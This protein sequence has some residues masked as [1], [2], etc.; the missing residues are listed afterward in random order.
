MKTLF[1]SALA[2]FCLLAVTFAQ[3]QAR[4]IQVDDLTK[5]ITVSDPQISP[6]G[7]FVVCVVS[8]QNLDQ[9]RA[10]HELV[11]VDVDTGSQRVL[12]YDRKDAGS[13]HWSPSG[14]R[15]AFTA[16]VAGGKDN[17][18]E[19]P[20]IF[21]LPM[22]G[23][24]AKKIT[25]AATGIEQFAWRPNGNDIAYVTSDEP[26]SKKQIEKYSDAFE[27]G[28]SDYLSK[29]A[30]KSSHIWLV[31][32]AGGDPKR[33]TSGSWSL[34]KNAP[35]SSPASPISW[36]PDGKFLTFV[37]Q[38]HPH[39]GDSDLATVQILTVDSG[40]IRKLTKHEKLEGF[41]L[42]SPDGSQ[43]TYWYPRDGDPNNE[44][45]I[46]VTAFAGGDGVDLTR[47]V[48][49]NLQRA[50]WMPDGKSLLVGGDDGTQVA[51]WLQPLQGSARK[52][53]LG[54]I[55]PTWFFWIDADVG[56]TGAIAFTGNSPAQ[57]S[58]L[59]YMASPDDPPKRL[60]DFNAPI[61]GLALGKAEKFE[62]KGPDGFHEDGVLVYPPEFKKDTK[63][64]LVLVIHGGPTAA[65]MVGFDSVAAI[66]QLLAAHDYVVF[67]PNYRGSDNLGNAY[68]RAIYNDAGGGPGRDVM[69]GIEA[70]KKLG[71]VDESKIAVSG[72]SYGGFMTS[73]L[74]GHYH[75]WKTAV[76]GASVTDLNEAYNLSDF[77]VGYRY[78]F[79]GSPWV[80]G[81]MKDYVAQSPIAYAAQIKTP[82]LIMSD[83]GDA[84]VPITQSY[85][86][87]H[88]L[89]DNGVVVKFIAYPIPG[90]F[91]EDPV[92]SKDVY[93]RWVAWID[94]YLK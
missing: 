54:D 80:G 83:T 4:R 38:E 77:N 3:A 86:L 31:P 81:N 1:L 37:K 47:T 66:S 46:F 14:D 24:D 69:A 63:Y 94:Q 28:D 22:N 76:A 33:L 10:D 89:K 18:E 70:V 30:L 51:M 9:D 20:Q 8:R 60:T 7:K 34:P 74:I 5:I 49:H 11:L 92:R 75:I 32:A 43:L 88:A 12:T 62:W 87:F 19:L 39:F 57:P 13:P 21:V 67:R 84:R 68:Q 26:E 48:D 53:R 40:E 25:N 44:N 29:A 64:P 61:A 52:L 71:F 85:Q 91:P 2:S 93:T 59:Y 27:V 65:S 72:W 6:N 17:K 79:K 50:I 56:R 35:F 55:S 23:G 73:W 41:G 78:G 45:E 16:V 36:T 42:F 82:T 90:H 15:L 58:E